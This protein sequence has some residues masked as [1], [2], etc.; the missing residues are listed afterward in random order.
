MTGVTPANITTLGIEN[1]FEKN[2]NLVGW[3]V[4]KNGQPRFMKKAKVQ[5]LTQMECEKREQLESNTIQS[6]AGG[7]I[8]TVAN[9]FTVLTVVS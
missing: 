8:C 3:A 7:K 5:I 1:F 6:S 9:P 2:V 4:A